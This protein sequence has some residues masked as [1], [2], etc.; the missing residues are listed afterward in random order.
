MSS[1][2]MIADISRILVERLQEALY[3]EDGGNLVM[4]KDEIGIGTDI[5]SPAPYLVGIYLYDIVPM[6]AMLYGNSQQM[7]EK[8]V[9]MLRYIIVVSGKDTMQ[10]RAKREHLIL[11]K[12]IETF[13]SSS[14]I[15][16]D[17]PILSQ[18]DEPVA[19]AM[20]GVSVE[21]KIRIRNQLKE[22]T[23]NL[24]Y[25]VYPVI[26]EPEKKKEQAKRVLEIGG[27]NDG[28]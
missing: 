4:N 22:L 6:D 20:S 24:F 5:N 16:R 1:Y 21:D 27:R 11:G 3:P 26:I 25:D 15:G 14:L 23:A 18:E 12:I 28:K 7:A 10:E 9:Y 2:S 19:I 8:A 13:Q 17:D